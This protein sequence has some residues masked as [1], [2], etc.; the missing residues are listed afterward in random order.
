MKRPDGITLIG[1]YHFLM[2]ALCAM[3]FLGLML[4][5]VL[6]GVSTIAVE[7]QDAQIPIAITGVVFLVIGGIVLI[8]GA[9]NLVLGIGIW[10]LRPWSRIA[11]LILAA[12]RLFSFPVGTAVGGLTIWYLLQPEVEVLFEG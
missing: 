7:M 6:V 11:V 1:L 12:F 5:P 8:V 4:I 9:V 10:N 2:A 3:G